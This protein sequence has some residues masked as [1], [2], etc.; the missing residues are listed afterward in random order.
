MIP[1]HIWMFAH[2]STVTRTPGWEPFA[3]KVCVPLVLVGAGL[4]WSALWRELAGDMA[5]RMPACVIDNG[6]G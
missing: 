1:G 5:V 6:T 2:V 3:W 4:L